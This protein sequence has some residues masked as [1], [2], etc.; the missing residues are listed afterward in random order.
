M[1]SQSLYSVEGK[2]TIKKKLVKYTEWQ[3]VE[4]AVEKHKLQ[5]R[6]KVPEHSDHNLK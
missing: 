2:Q 6:G 3:M 5:K 4:D 1:L